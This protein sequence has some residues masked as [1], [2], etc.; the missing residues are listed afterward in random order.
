MR[1]W[2][3]ASLG[4]GKNNG[5]MTV[6]LWLDSA[7]ATPNPCDADMPNGFMA[8]VSKVDGNPDGTGD[9][10]FIYAVPGEIEFCDD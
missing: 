8:Y 4:V 9:G 10:E 5:P 2:S 7:S 3:F 6:D 1:Q